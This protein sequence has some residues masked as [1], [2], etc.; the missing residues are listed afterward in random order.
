M[1]TNK[2]PSFETHDLGL[3]DDTEWMRRWE[4]YDRGMKELIATGD[5]HQDEDGWWIETATGELVGPDPSIER[6][7]TSSEIAGMR[8]LEEVLPELA[9]SIKRSRGR[10][11]KDYPKTAVTLRIDPRVVE[12]Y[13]AD[14]ADWRAR[15]AEALERTASSR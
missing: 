11:A 4:A 9:E 13:Q 12:R 15:M 7:L 14:G 10:P 3:D 1:T 5:F 8:P 6:P 2:W